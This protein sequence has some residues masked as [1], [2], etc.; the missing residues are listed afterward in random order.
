MVD[1]QALQRGEPKARCAFAKELGGRTDDAAL[2][3]AMGRMG[4]D[5]D[6]RQQYGPVGH[7][8]IAK[9]FSIDSMIGGHERLY[10]G[11]VGK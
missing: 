5:T 4:A 9:D 6:L 8:R 1:P 10:E 3:A 11:V 7:D 2:A